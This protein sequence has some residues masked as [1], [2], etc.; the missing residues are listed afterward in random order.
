MRRLSP[1]PLTDLNGIECCS[2]VFLLGM[3]VQSTSLL[4]SCYDDYF[5]IF[6]FFAIII[7]KNP[8]EFFPNF[9]YPKKKKVKI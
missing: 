7:S 8:L 4:C 9:N 1:V 5:F 2:G 3:Y 6:F